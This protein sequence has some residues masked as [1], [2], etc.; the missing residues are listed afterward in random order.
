VSVDWRIP[1]AEARRQLPDVALQG[2][3][4]STLLLGPP[5]T[6]LARVAAILEAVGHQ[7]GYIFNLGHGIQPPTPPQHVKALVD[8]VHA[9]RP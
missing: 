9:F 7:P 5:E 2:N 8:A 6:M 4:D 1:I 3:L